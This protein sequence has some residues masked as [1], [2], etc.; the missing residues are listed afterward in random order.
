[1][2]Y[3]IVSDARKTIALL[4]IDKDTKEKISL[5]FEHYISV[6]EKICNTFTSHEEKLKYMVSIT[7]KFLERL[8]AFLISDGFP[9][10]YVLYIIRHKNNYN[11]DGVP[12]KSLDVLY[13]KII[14]KDYSLEYYYDI[15]FYTNKNCNIVNA[16]IEALARHMG[17]YIQP[18]DYVDDSK[19]PLAKVI[20][21]VE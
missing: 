12:D 8:E 14:T 21:S 9:S 2:N 10:R 13:R 5:V 11:K 1:M 19:S 17:C 18:K 7:T 15:L 16:D 3:K 20:R 4:G 6:A